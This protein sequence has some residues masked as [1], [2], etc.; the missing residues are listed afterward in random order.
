MTFQPPADALSL[1]VSAAD[2]GEEIVW[3]GTGQVV[4]LDSAPDYPAQ[5]TLRRDWARECLL[6]LDT[7]GPPAAGVDTTRDDVAKA[8]PIIDGGDVVEPFCFSVSLG[9]VSRRSFRVSDV[10]IGDT[11]E[12]ADD[13]YVGIAS[14]IPY[15]GAPTRTGKGVDHR[16]LDLVADP[17]S[18][19]IDCIAG[20]EFPRTGRT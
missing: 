17:Y 15:V 11:S 7:E 19:A 14:W 3:N 5:M 16:R 18:I 13:V 10:T 6:T 2:S 12:S 20:V 4:D 8:S 1:P 9:S